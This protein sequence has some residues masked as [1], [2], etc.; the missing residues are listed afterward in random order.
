MEQKSEE[1][2]KIRVVSFADYLVKLIFFNVT[3]NRFVNSK[4]VERIEMVAGYYRA[5][6]FKRKII[7]F[8]AADFLYN[9]RLVF[10]KRIDEYSSQEIRKLCK[11]PR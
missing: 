3:F 11:N 6:V 9:H 10:Y 1:A 7:F 2:W 8:Q 5:L 4:I